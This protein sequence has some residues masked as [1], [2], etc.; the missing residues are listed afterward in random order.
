MNNFKL[1][2]TKKI[3]LGLASLASVSLVG[4][5]ITSCSEVDNSILNNLVGLNAT[6]SAKYGEKE[7]SWKEQIKNALND[8][9]STKE[10]KKVL[11]DKILYN[12]YYELAFGKGSRENQITSFADN[13]AKWYDSAAQAYDDAV[14]QNKTDHKNNWPYYFRINVLDPINATGG[15]FFVERDGSTTNTSSVKQ[16]YIKNKMMENIRSEFNSLVWKSVDGSKNAYFG[17]SSDTKYSPYTTN[18]TAGSAAVAQDL[19]KT[20]E[21]W[22]KLDFYA[23]LDP[24]YRQD[25]VNMADSLGWMFAY[26]QHITFKEYTDYNNPIS[27]FMALWKYNDPTGG[28]KSV[29]NESLVTSADNQKVGYNFPY[30]QDTTSATDGPNS[31]FA[32]TI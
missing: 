5:T 31:K 1:T 28:W 18:V 16:D 4:A 25:S 26:I 7:F 24:N 2:K 20:P 22:Q 14:S 6:N 3:L 9:T 30:F 23:K 10:F 11:A 15:H 29:Y 12:W 19:L 27:T 13:W 21:N 17:L 8:E 32:K